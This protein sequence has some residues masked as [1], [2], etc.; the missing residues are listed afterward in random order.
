M[1]WRPAWTAETAARTR[2]K[3]MTPVV[4]PH[5]FRRCRQTGAAPTPFTRA[6][7]GPRRQC[8]QT[9]RAPI[10]M[11]SMTERRRR[12][13]LRRIVRAPV[14]R[15]PARPVCPRWRITSRTPA[16][17]PSVDQ[18]AYRHELHQSGPVFRRAA[19]LLGAH[20]VGGQLRAGR[21]EHHPSRRLDSR[22][23][24]LRRRKHADWRRV[25]RGP[26]MCPDR[27]VS[28]RSRDVLHRAKRVGPLPA[29]LPGLANLLPIFHGHACVYAMRVR[30][31]HG[32][33]LPVERYFRGCVP[34]RRLRH[35]SLGLR[36]PA[37]LLRHGRRLG[38]RGRHLHALWRY[39]Y[40]DG[41]HGDRFFH[42]DHADD[43][44]LHSLSALPSEGDPS[45][46]RTRPH[47]TGARPPAGGG[48][49]AGG[50]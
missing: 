50:R 12:M 9:A 34:V 45:H 4:S 13:P 37:G 23:A 10:P 18:S 36:R 49:E 42:A 20:S 6:A 26:D 32:R 8:P 43:D 25:Q 3:A 38:R 28:V 47:K 40:S 30:R 5:A 22:R 29:Q 44:L 33:D 41:R 31:G 46:R 2:P 24:P 19:H 35:L 39:V 16:A 21:R 11:P 7:A 14:G 1:S 17:P 15:R 27:C 48:Q